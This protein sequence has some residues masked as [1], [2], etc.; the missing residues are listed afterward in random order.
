MSLIEIFVL[1]QG[2]SGGPLVAGQYQ[3]GIASYVR[4]CALGSPDVFARVYSFLDWI[5]QHSSL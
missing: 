4:P 5:E 2:D 1:F 3:I